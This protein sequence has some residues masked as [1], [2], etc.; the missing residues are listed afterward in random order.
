MTDLIPRGAIVCGVDG[1]PSSNLALTRAAELARLERRPLHVLHAERVP[2]LAFPPAV[3]RGLPDLPTMVRGESRAVARRAVTAVTRDFPDLDVSSSVHDADPREAL[4][5]A[6]GHAWLV[7][8]GSR[9]LGSM[10]SL[11]LGSVSVWASQHIACPTLV[12]RDDSGADDPAAPVVVGADG[13]PLS[14]S[15]VEFAFA[16]ASFL[17]CPLVVMNCYDD[18]FRG[19]YGMTGAADEQL[20]DLGGHR[21]ALAESIAGLREKYVD[22]PVE[23]EVDR[24][25]AATRLVRASEHARLVV[26]GSRHRSTAAAMLG[27]AVSRT[28][29]EHA[30]CTVAVVPATA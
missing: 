10:R 17:G 26:V 22:V 2:V 1:S 9:G 24:G 30:R 27:G 3:Q 14:T 21:L 8:V 18:E 12:V 28:V 5:A 15:A 19:G 6:S 16:Q 25:P 11:L 29:V 7:V 4:A 20:D 13:T 23:L